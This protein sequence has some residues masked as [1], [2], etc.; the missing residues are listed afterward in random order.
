MLGIVSLHP[1]LRPTRLRSRAVALEVALIAVLYVGYSASRTLASDDRGQ[2]LERAKDLLGL[3]R[4]WHLDV[5]QALNTWFVHHDVAAVASSFWYATAHY[6]V[7]AVVLV[8]MF[9]RRPGL[10]GRARTALVV[11]SLTGLAFYLTVPLAP[12]RFVEGYADVLALHSSVGW[13]GADASAPK[14]M[15]G[16]TNELAAFPSLHAGWALWV[17]LVVASAG[18]GRAWRLAGWAYALVTAVV[19]VGTGNHWLLDVVGGWVVVAVAWVGVEVVGHRRRAGGG[20]GP[21]AAG[22]AVVPPD[23]VVTTP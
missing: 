9:V 20:A 8:W 10:Y 2:A 15:G 16:L 19:V 7:T 13:W 22:G 1:T 3:E 4:A 11:A 12:P 23:D 5:E 18:L 17:A 21:R 14:G 6:L